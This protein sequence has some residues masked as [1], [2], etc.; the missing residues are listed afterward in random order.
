[1]IVEILKQKKEYM[2]AQCPAYRLDCAILE[3]LTDILKD[4]PEFLEYAAN[5]RAHWQEVQA[6]NYEHGKELAA[7]G[8]RQFRSWDNVT[9]EE[10][11]VGRPSNTVIHAS[12]RAIIQGAP[13]ALAGFYQLYADVQTCKED[14]ETMFACFFG[15]QA[16]NPSPTLLERVRAIIEPNREYACNWWPSRYMLY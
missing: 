15:V 6:A 4:A 3:A 8:A 1:M 10:L 7:R 14:F 2:F 5:M 11:L 13:E 9:Q 16:G 12:W